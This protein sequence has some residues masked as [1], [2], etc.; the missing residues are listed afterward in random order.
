MPSDFIR[1]LE[2]AQVSSGA[3]TR[4]TLTGAR[5]AH[6][7]RSDLAAASRLSPSNARSATREAENRIT[8]PSP[9][10]GGGGSPPPSAAASPSPSPMGRSCHTTSREAVKSATRSAKKRWL[11]RHDSPGRRRLR[12]APAAAAE[13]EEDAPGPAVGRW[14]AASACAPRRHIGVEHRRRRGRPRS[15]WQRVRRGQWGV[16]SCSLLL[17]LHGT[18]PDASCG[19]V[20]RVGR[21]LGSGEVRWRRTAVHLYCI[22]VLTP[23]YK[24]TRSSGRGYV[25]V[26]VFVVCTMR[27]GLGLWYLF[28]QETVTD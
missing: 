14:C 9:P 22:H 13:E 28:T 20:G 17:L 12:A 25:L 6:R 1:V 5:P 18:R 2:T 11:G 21:G 27:N 24:R 26:Y 4:A 8:P 15:E 23:E 7:R 16:G 3:L 10:S 19:R